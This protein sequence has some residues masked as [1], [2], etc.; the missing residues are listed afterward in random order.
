[1]AYKA[2]SRYA[3][4]RR[5]VVDNTVSPAL[6][7]VVGL[8]I[9]FILAYGMVATKE[10]Q[11]VALVVGLVGITAIFARPYWGL[12]LFIALLYMRPEES[13]P[14]LQGMRFTLLV[15]VCT[16]VALYFQLFL[17]RTPLVQ[18]PVNA[19]ILG[20]GA[21]A[22]VSTF[23]KGSLLAVVTDF[24]K[25]VIL[26]LLVL[27]LIR[28]P[29]RYR[30]FVSAMMLFTSYLALFSI[31]L[32]F[33]GGAMKY[34]GT[35]DRSVATGIFSD[36]NDLAAAII[37]GLALALTRIATAP[38]GA[39]VFYFLLTMM[40]IWAILLT[41]SRGGLLALMAVVGGYFFTFSR[42]KI[43]ASVAAVMVIVLFL[44][45]AP[46]R[47]TDFDNKEESANSR[48]WFWANGILVLKSNPITGV[49]YDNFAPLNENM[50]AH[51][52]FVQCFAEL[53]LAGYFCWMGCIYY[54]FRPR[55]PK[56][57]DAGEET[58]EREMRELLG[59]RLALAGFLTACFWITRTFVPVTYLMISLP[60]AHQ[61]AYNRNGIHLKLSREDLKQDIYRI[62]A[63]T[64]GSVFAI[65]II[66]NVMR[67]KG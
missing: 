36:P 32:Y 29:E 55:R 56:D 51:N 24:G 3:P 7:L 12:V 28:T 30:T 49:G 33:Q 58:D 26:V 9:P 27:N 53:G 66:A 54:G 17:S 61:I 10:T 11:V 2:Q 45:V 38:R 67:H 64:L 41:N 6:L 8:L 50:V 21:V 60:I 39:K 48:F 22:V 18:S 34:T 44:A 37:G 40:M 31:F 25:L 16:L 23:G 14:A 46:S 42:H 52:S 1:M 47:M 63:L 19:L 62:G 13:I 65:Y 15:S 4:P 20:F 5:V 57:E 35:I 43:A 59:A